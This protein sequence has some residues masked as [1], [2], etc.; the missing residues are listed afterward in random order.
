MGECQ[1]DIATTVDLF[2]PSKRPKAFNNVCV[3]PTN[4][5]SQLRLALKVIDKVQMPPTESLL[6]IA[7]VQKA[8]LL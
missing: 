6:A 5:P 7:C 2:V 3:V 8:R 4:T 1:R